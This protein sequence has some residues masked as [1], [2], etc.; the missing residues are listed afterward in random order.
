MEYG[1]LVVEDGNDL[2][3]ILG[4][5]WSLDEA[6]ELADNYERNATPDNPDTEVPPTWY[7][8]MRRNA[9]GFYTMREA[10]DHPTNKR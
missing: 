10:L 5:V 7:I 8:I 4:A 9:N 1:I 3:Q 6:R 2:W